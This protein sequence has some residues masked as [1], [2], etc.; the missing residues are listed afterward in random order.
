MSNPAA[1][2]KG[3]GLRRLSAEY[4]VPFFQPG[5]LEE[6]YASVSRRLD[7][8]EPRFER[9]VRRHDLIAESTA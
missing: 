8:V 2:N 7:S 4:I 3:Y 5:A 1:R 9:V 6:R